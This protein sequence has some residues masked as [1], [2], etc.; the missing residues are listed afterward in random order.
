MSKNQAKD[1]SRETHI[2][3]HPLLDCCDDTREA[4]RDTRGFDESQAQNSDDRHH[5]SQSELQQITRCI[6]FFNGIWDR[7]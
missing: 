6:A 5:L 7:T 3:L 4:Q 2:A 1:L